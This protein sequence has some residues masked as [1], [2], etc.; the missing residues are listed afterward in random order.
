MQNQMKSARMISE[1]DDTLA[2]LDSTGDGI[3]GEDG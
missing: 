3:S 2:V 1:E